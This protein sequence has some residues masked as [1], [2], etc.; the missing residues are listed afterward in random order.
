MDWR[1]KSQQ[2]ISVK[3]FE[4]LFEMFI[5][6]KVGLCDESL[7]RDKLILSRYNEANRGDVMNSLVE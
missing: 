5:E 7:R 4:T 3:P 2:H 6:M 1:S